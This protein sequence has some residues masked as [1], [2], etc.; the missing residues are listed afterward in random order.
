MPSAPSSTSDALSS[1]PARVMLSALERGRLSHS[2]IIS[3]DD[4]DQVEELGRSLAQRILNQDS[5]AA[6]PLDQHPDFLSVRPAGKMRQIS[7]DDTRELVRKISLSASIGK[8]KVAILFEAD[9]LHQSSANIFLKTLEEPPA[10]TTIILLT[11]RPQYLL[12]TI[13]SRC[14]HFRLP[15]SRRKEPFPEG[16]LS[17][18]SEYS[19]WLEGLG[20]EISSKRAVCDQVMRMYGLLARF[21]PMLKTAVAEAWKAQ[22]ESLPENISEDE[23]DALAEGFRLELRDEVFGAI[24]TRLRA[25]FLNQVTTNASSARAFTRSVDELER[26]AGLLRVNLNETAALESF[27][28][29][30]LR[31][32]GRKG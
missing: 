15:I 24:E 16:V 20:G 29:G 31:A 10:G 5:P 28:L 27:F 19:R 8:N 12:P 7:A 21:S 9:R 18:L 1:R 26:I 32:W 13:R 6:A 2:L 3:G 30:T 25:F 22:K 11:V 14:L 17:W 23:E 4:G